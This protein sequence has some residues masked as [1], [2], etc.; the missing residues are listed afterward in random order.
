MNKQRSIPEKNTK[1]STPRFPEIEKLAVELNFK[2]VNASLFMEAMT[3]S[4]Y[5]NEHG[6]ASNELL[7][8]LGDSILSLI[9]CNFLYNQYPL[10]KEGELAKLKAIIVSSPILAGLARQTGLDRYIK[11]GQ[12]EILA[13]G[14]TKP[15]I[16]ADLFEAFIGAYFLN[17][18]LEG[19][20]N[21]LIPMI[22]P[23]L[24][25]ITSQ[26]EFIDAKSN[27][28]ELAQSMGFK[29]D[30]RVIRE[31]GPPHNRLFT[32]EVWLNNEIKGQGTGRTLKEAQNQAAR[33]GLTHLRPR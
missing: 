13:K 28:Q 8:F 15:H 18:G 27:F 19:A 11:L 9:V 31:E 7:E 32:V 14:N 23:L 33:A 24:P 4:S 2:P 5:A 21:F 10:Q 16:L 17:F 30:Y 3:H 12:G 1:H 20:T 26:S 25:E 29:P 22:K 6:S